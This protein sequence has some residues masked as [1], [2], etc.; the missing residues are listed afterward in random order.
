MR[1]S[2]RLALPIAFV[3]L[4]MHGCV[5]SSADQ[6][7]AY[8]L[9]MEAASNSDDWLNEIPEDRQVD[10]FFAS[11]RTRPESRTVD[12]WIIEDNPKFIH[13]LRNSISRRGS[14][15]D[16]DAFLFIIEAIQERA[17]MSP[18]EMSSLELRELCL[19]LG[20]GAEGCEEQI[21][22]I[23]QRSRE[24]LKANRRPVD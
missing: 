11:H 18:E 6:D 17:G 14:P 13:V 15:S 24:A 22:E 20:E 12:Y 3:S 4:V 5:N 8:F 2:M 1:M 7:T 19:E 21:A 9:S 10:M 23:E 16:V